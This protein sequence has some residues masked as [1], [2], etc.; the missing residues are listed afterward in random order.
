MALGSDTRGSVRIPSALCGTTGF[1]PTAARVP[2]DGAFPLSYTL[3]SVGPLANS[4]A[5]CA[6]FDAILS[7]ERPAA[8]AASPPPLPVERLQLLLPRCGLFDDVEPVVSAAFEAATAQRTPTLT[9]TPTPTPDLNPNPNHNRNANPELHPPTPTPPPTLT[10]ARPPR[11][12]CARQ[13]LP[14]YTWTHPCSIARRPSSSPTEASRRR[15]RGTHTASYWPP[16]RPSP[17]L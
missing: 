14:W 1:K 4:V 5:C 16:P 3:D 11:P 9:P 6:L 2:R 15:R 8:L 10:L 12:S 13:G 7:G 17:A